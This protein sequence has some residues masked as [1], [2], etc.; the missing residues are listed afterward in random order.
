MG[1]RFA[2]TRNLGVVLSDQDSSRSP[3]IAKVPEGTTGLPLIA[4]LL[5][6]LPI[7]I[8][9]LFVAGIA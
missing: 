2:P 7:P 5:L 3:V 6:G 4:V 8:A 9:Y 1:A